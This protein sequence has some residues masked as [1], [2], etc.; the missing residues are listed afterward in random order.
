[1]WEEASL[2]NCTFRKDTAL[3]SFT[4]HTNIR[5][6]KSIHSC[7]CAKTRCCFIT[8]GPKNFINMQVKHH[9]QIFKQKSGIYLAMI[10][11]NTSENKLGTFHLVEKYYFEKYIHSNQ[12]EGFQKTVEIPLQES[13]VKGGGDKMKHLDWLPLQGTC[14]A[15]ILF[16]MSPLAVQVSF[17]SSS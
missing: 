12:S 6:T 10:Q 11:T 8:C 5:H 17:N 4:R 1:M 13:P 14:L 15:F 3:V 7:S 9:A 2:S 16:W